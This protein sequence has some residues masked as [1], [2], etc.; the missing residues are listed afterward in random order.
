MQGRNCHGERAQFLYADKALADLRMLRFRVRRNRLV[1]WR[2]AHTMSCLRR[3]VH[4]T[5]RH[6]TFVRTYELV[7]VSLRAV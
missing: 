3:E 5:S 6:S 4:I 7:V 2:W 1:C